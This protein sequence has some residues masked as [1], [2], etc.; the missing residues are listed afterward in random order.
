MNHACLQKV[1]LF[2]CRD[3]YLIPKGEELLDK[4]FPGESRIPLL[5]METNVSLGL[6]YGHPLLLDGMRP[7]APNFQYLGMMNCRPAEELPK[8]LADFMDSG[9]EHGVIFV[10][11]GS[12]LSS[13][14]MSEDMRKAF[15]N[16][17]GSL[18]Q[19]VLWKWETEEMQDKPD[20][21]KLSKWLPQQDILGH[22]NTKLFISHVGQSSFQ[23]SLCHQKPMVRNR[24][25]FFPAHENL[26]RTPLNFVACHSCQC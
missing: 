2:C 14:E 18:K 26:L 22:P 20:N 17:F 24:K 5:E 4:H 9:K 25:S 10:S 3:F 16:A 11:F 1:I 6:H 7:V 13:K 23:E 15:V 12:I 21:L 19:K 8:D